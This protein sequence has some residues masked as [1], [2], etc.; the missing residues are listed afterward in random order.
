[1]HPERTDKPVHGTFTVTRV[2]VSPTTVNLNVP[3]NYEQT[4]A[5]AVDTGSA[6]QVNNL[7]LLYDAA[8]QPD[9]T[10]PE[11]IH[12]TLG[13]GGLPSGCRQPGHPDLHDLGRQHGGP[14]RHT[15]PQGQKR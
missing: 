6:T 9:G 7:E 13:D 8:D 11:G 12:V 15:G 5:I 4:I 3:R 1:M 2:S 14:E 10:L